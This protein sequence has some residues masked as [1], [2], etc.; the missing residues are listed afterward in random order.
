MN[1]LKSIKGKNWGASSKLIIILYK[2]LVRPLLEYVPFATLVL[3]M[4]QYL[5]LEKIQRQA[6]RKAIYWPQG[7][8]TK[9]IYQQYNIRS[10]QDRAIYLTNNYINRA[11]NLNIIAYFYMLP[12]FTNKHHSTTAHANIQSTTYKYSHMQ[13]F[14]KLHRQQLVLVISTKITTL[15]FIVFFIMQST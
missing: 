6:V 12:T 5:R 15:S 1:L 10:I 2:T 4:S 3:T 13:I 14:T 11:H 9:D 8:S 7:V